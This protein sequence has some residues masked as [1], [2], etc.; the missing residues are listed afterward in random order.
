MSEDA[1]CL[2]E[3]HLKAM[4]DSSDR[5]LPLLIGFRVSGLSER[6]LWED[7]KSLIRSLL[8]MN[9]RERQSGRVSVPDHNRNVL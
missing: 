9:P 7:A 1:F 6:R 5:S 2:K 8:K 4:A 3:K